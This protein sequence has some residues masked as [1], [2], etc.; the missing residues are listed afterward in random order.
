MSNHP[1]DDTN[2]SQL[3]SRAHR[4]QGDDEANILK[5]LPIHQWRQTEQHV[6]PPSE[7]QPT[8]VGKQTWP[9]L[10]MPRDSHLL[11]EVS[12]QLLRA[13]RAGKLYQ[14]PVSTIDDEDKDNGLD[15][16]EQKETPVGFYVRKWTQVPRHL[17]E[18]EPEHLAKRR[19]GLPPTFGSNGVPVA[20]AA[21]TLR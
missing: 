11:P 12:Q 14:P 6:V 18:P 2:Q 20:P 17:E 10:P 5:G 21:S 4:A 19:K 1:D 16:E 15:E 7:Q 3:R 13:A 9:E 8:G